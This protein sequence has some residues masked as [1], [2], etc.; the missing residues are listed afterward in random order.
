MARDAILNRNAFTLKRTTH[1][2]ELMEM[3]EDNDGF[4]VLIF[5]KRS[6]A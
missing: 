6:M 2:V 5:M 4:T 1:I 3:A